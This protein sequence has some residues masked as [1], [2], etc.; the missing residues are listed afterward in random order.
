LE[1]KGIPVLLTIQVD[2]IAK[3]GQ[4]DSTIPANVASAVNFYQPRG[5]LHGRSEILAADPSRTKIIGNFRMTYKDHPINCDNYP[6]YARTFNKPHHEIE[7]DPR[8]W[9]QAASLIDSELSSPRST[10]QASS[11]SQSPLFK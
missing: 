6:W 10:A 11:P 4:K 5:V 3:P 9:D 8:V 2:S 1:R 7:N